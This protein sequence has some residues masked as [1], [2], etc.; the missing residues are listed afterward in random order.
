VW[1]S[2]TLGLVVIPG[3]AWL[4]R[5]LQR[6][7]N[8]MTPR[9]RRRAAVLSIAFPLSWRELLERRYAHYRRLPG[10]LRHQ[11]EKKVQLFLA[12]RRITGIGIEAS[13]ELKLLVAASAVTLSLSW[14]DYDW[15]DIGE[16]LLYP[17]S[18]GRD[19]AVGPGEK[20]AGTAHPWGTV[21]L[22][23]PALRRSFEQ[24]DDGYHAGIHEFAHLL[25]V[26]AT[27][28]DG[29]P[30]WLTN[31]QVATWE[32]IRDREMQRLQQ[33]DSI[34]D[35]YGAYEPVEFMAVAIESFFERPQALRS[36]HS[37]LYEV[38]ADY[39]RQDPATWEDAKGS[40]HCAGPFEN[41]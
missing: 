27:R 36:N 34:L 4:N 14:P 5:L 22:S 15:D 39:F 6:G 12:E 24:G 19:F 31:K 7:L 35:T 25:D 16:V 2:C 10:N 13:D 32:Q 17:D 28:F 30:S 20:W 26:E 8:A 9:S 38:L 21:I 33:G 37:Q 41:L 3:V 11:F 1:F 23:V 40:A 29:I 18:F